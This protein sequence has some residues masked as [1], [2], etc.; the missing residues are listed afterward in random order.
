MHTLTTSESFRI[1]FLRW[2]CGK[3]VTGGACIIAIHYE[4]VRK[5]LMLSRGGSWL[6]I[7][8]Y[9]VP[10]QKPGKK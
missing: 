9:N 4:I 1:I 10:R 5:R 8:Q 2:L 7:Y 3:V 6:G